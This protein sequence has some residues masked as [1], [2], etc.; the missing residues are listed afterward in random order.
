MTDES[1]KKLAP[2]IH[3]NR[4]ELAEQVRSVWSVT[5]P[6]ETTKEDL[7]RPDFWA[8][9]ASKLRPRA[10]VEV[11]TEDGGYIAN[12]VVLDSGAQ[13][14]RMALLQEFKLDVVS[15]NTEQFSLPGHSVGWSG[16]HTKWRVTRDSDKKVLRDGFNN[17]S[18]AYAW[19]AGHA[20]ALAA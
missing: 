9:V 12:L 13:Y 1:A 20:R 8:H 19:L 14:V 6:N 18:D 16:R 4:M 11:E 3:P 17:K 7:L 5:V 10:R 15:P 2:A